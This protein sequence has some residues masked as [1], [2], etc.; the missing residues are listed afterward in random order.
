MS[1]PPK[2]DFLGWIAKA[3]SVDGENVHLGGLLNPE[4]KKDA[5]QDA[6][7]LLK[8]APSNSQ[9]I[10]TEETRLV[11]PAEKEPFSFLARCAFCQVQ[12]TSAIFM[13]NDEQYCCQRHR[14]QAETLQQAQGEWSALRRH[15]PRSSPS[16]YSGSTRKLRCWI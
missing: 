5:M 7:A 3:M 8:L 16:P 11:S 14:S 13:F 2:I 15:R 6:E 9:S 12:I 1:S 10:S 4:A